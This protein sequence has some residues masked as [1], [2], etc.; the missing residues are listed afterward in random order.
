MLRLVVAALPAVA[1]LAFQSAGLAFQAGPPRPVQDI[2][3]APT[4][5]DVDFTFELQRPL[6]YELTVHYGPIEGEPS[7][8]V[9]YGVKAS[10][11][12]EAALKSVSFD[13]IDDAGAPIQRIA[14]ARQATGISGDVEFL[15]LMSVPDRPFRVRL[16]GESVDGRSVRRVF[17]RR[18]VPT[19]A[20]PNDSP[21][22][23][24]EPPEIGRTFQQ[25]FEAL[26]PGVVAERES[27]IAR[28]RADAVTLP[29]TEISN[30]AYAPLFGETGRPIGIRVTY[31]VT[32]SET[33]RYNPALLVRTARMPGARRADMYIVAATIDPRPNQVSPNTGGTVGRGLFHVAD[34]LYRAE[35]VYRFTVDLVPGYARVDERAMNLCV[36]PHALEQQAAQAPAQGRNDTTA[37]RLSI[38]GGT[39]DG[40]IRYFGP[41][42][43]YQNLIA[44]GVQ[45]CR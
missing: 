1:G 44:E 41:A 6:L 2:T 10:I 33:G 30:V 17:R 36:D 26:A 35:T 3:T 27:L 16:I 25:M 43:L 11:D 20:P 34:F 29:R 18:F 15:G 40:T 24:I 42:T 8:G 31:S 12:G 38:G 21:Y 23:A 37:Y 19:Q 5:A 28:S 13:A 7:I 39:F 22:A 4:L 45:N 32:F 9:Q 14:I